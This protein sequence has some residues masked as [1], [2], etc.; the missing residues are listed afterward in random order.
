MPA[1]NGSSSPASTS[2]TAIIM[3]HSFAALS[4]KPASRHYLRYVSCRHPVRLRFHHQQLA[5]Q[6]TIS[7]HDSL[8]IQ[9]STAAN[10][11]RSTCS[12]NA[13][14]NVARGLET[15]LVHL[16]FPSSCVCCL[17]N[18][19]KATALAFGN[20]GGGGKEITCSNSCSH[21]RLL[22]YV[23]SRT[24]LWLVMPCAWMRR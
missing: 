22:G 7:L 13:V 11:R 8:S 20:R 17:S 5:P 9:R 23:S 19:H 6:H 4:F 3:R 2:S 1:F 21:G 12:P 24:W 15:G 14:T 10:C 18:S 16:T